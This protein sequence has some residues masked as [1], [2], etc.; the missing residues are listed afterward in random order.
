MGGIA[1]PRRRRFRTAPL[2]QVFVYSAVGFGVWMTIFGAHH[3]AIGGMISGLLF[4]AAMTAY[5]A[6]VRRRDTESTGTPLASVGSLDEMIRSGTPPVDP[7]Q[8]QAMRALIARRRRQ[9]AV[10]RWLSPIV[11]G[12]FTLL[13][14]ALAIAG[15]AWP[16]VL[17]PVVFAGFMVWSAIATRRNQRRLDIMDAALG[18]Q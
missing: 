1:E 14:L 9:V 12:M 15:P 5:V 13:G 2:W 18:G 17:F 3:S 4:G 6:K 7:E 11:F 10:G 8:R 16:N